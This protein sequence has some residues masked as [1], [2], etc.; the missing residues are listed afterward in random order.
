MSININSKS[1]ALTVSI[2][3]YTVFVFQVEENV[4]EEEMFSSQLLPDH[5]TRYCELPFSFDLLL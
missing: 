3:N 1:S 4:A 2:C 5:C